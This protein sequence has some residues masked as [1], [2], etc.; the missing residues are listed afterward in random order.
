[1]PPLEEPAL[2][3]Y[4][5]TVPHAGAG[6]ALGPPP[7]FA[8]FLTSDPLWSL[9]CLSVRWSMW[10]CGA[11]GTG[12]GWSRRP[13]PASCLRQVGYGAGSHLAACRSAE[14]AWLS[15][16]AVGHCLLT[17]HG[18]RCS[19]SPAP[20]PTPWSLLESPPTP[21]CGLRMKTLAA[22]LWGAVS[23]VSMWD[24]VWDWHPWACGDCG[25]RPGAEWHMVGYTWD[26]GQRQP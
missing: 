4:F 2:P 14:K 25:R 7:L 5:G 8:H 21:H 11:L 17:L 1:M 22:P 15:L 16:S 18:A 12:Q 20:Q 6:G 23:L 3:G 19:L 24:R 10:C 26:L 9:V 13:L